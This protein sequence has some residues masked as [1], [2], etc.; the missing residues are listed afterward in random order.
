MLDYFLKNLLLD[1][2]IDKANTI[3]LFDKRYKNEIITSSKG[4]YK[5]IENKEFERIKFYYLNRKQI[6]FCFCFSNFP[7]PKFINCRSLIYFQNL[8]LLSSRNFKNII[9]RNY[10]RFLVDK[11]QKFIFQTNNTKELFNKKINGDV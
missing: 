7:P 4:N 9:K 2:K 6:N 11:N 10:L 3:F 8:T 1:S 5:F